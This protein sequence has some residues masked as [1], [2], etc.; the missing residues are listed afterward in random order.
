MV[1]RRW[2]GAGCVVDGVERVVLGGVAP[3]AV[4]G[5]VDFPLEDEED[6]RLVDGVVA[7]TF[8]SIAPLDVPSESLTSFDADDGGET[9]ARPTAM[10]TDAVAASPA[11]TN[12]ARRA[13]CLRLPGRPAGDRLELPAR[14]G[15]VPETG[16]AA[17]ASIPAAGVSTQAW[18]SQTHTGAWEAPG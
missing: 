5:V 1:G 16:V 2:I 17:T 9:T 3:R 7:G 11:A 4:D 8:G 6:D 18:P 15:R 12:R 10:P 14:T 13:G